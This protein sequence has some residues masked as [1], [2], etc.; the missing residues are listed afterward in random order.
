MSVMDY[1]KAK[2]NNTVQHRNQ[3]TP[4]KKGQR[5]I[6]PKKEE[7]QRRVRQSIIMVL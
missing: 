2:S 1:E 4:S 6:Y 3:N 7:L 5:R